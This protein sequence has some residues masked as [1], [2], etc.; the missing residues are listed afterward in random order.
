MDDIKL[1]DKNGKELETQVQA[2]IIYCQNIWMEWGIAKYTMIIMKSGKDKCQN[3]YN[4]Q[5]KKEWK[6]LQKRKFSSI[7]K[8]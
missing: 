2:E 3:E 6:R 4:Y 7:R 1:I 5:I 8:Y